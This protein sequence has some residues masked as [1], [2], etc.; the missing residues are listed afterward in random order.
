MGRSYALELAKRGCNVVVND[1]RSPDSV[2]EEIKSFGGVAVPDT[3]DIT[4]GQSVVETALQHF[5]AV[6]ILVN[7]A[8]ILRDKSFAKLSPVDWSSVLNVHLQG[9]FSMCHAVWPGM[10]QRGYGRII[11]VGSG[12]GC[13]GNFGQANYSAAK[14][15]IVG[16]SQT[17]AKEGVKHNIRVNTILPIAASKMT[18]NLMSPELLQLISPEH[19]APLVAYLA[20]EA[21]E[22]TGELF[23]CGGGWFAA[24]RY[25][26]ASG[27]F[28]ATESTT[29]VEPASVESIHA[30]IHQLRDFS[31]PQYPQSPADALSALMQAKSRGSNVVTASPPSP[32]SSSPV[33]P[34]DAL[35]STQ[36]LQ[37]MERAMTSQPDRYPV[38]L[39]P[40]SFTPSSP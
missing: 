8:G 18:E 37:R 5:G 4:N 38:S 36:F 40:P 21:C 25:Q 22:P 15:G 9:T 6:D 7:N 33:T 16:L 12:A 2:I 14:M 20:H 17:L 27:L 19:V 1:I 24:V 13:Y 30:H 39:S 34:P 35:P 31:S 11:N 3:N 29:A 26:R 10:M 28:L 23:E 32:P